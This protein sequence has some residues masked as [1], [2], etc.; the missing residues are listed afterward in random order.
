[1]TTTSQSLLFRY[2][3]LNERA[4]RDAAGRAVDED[5][6]R[7][8]QDLLGAWW[9][10]ASTLGA[11]HV[12]GLRDGRVETG[13]RYAVLLRQRQHP[14]TGARLLRVCVYTEGESQAFAPTDL[15]A[16]EGAVAYES[17]VD[18]AGR[19]LA[20]GIEFSALILGR[21]L[22]VQNR[23]GAGAAATMQRLIH[24]AGRCVEGSRFVRPTFVQVTPR[25]VAEQIAR[26]GGVAAVSFAPLEVQDDAGAR[27][28][29]QDIVAL[30]RR[31]G[32]SGR[33]KISAGGDDILDEEESLK[34]FDDPTGE[35][36]ENVR[37]HLKNNETISG[38]RM[39]MSHHVRIELRNGVPD[40]DRV[41]AALLDYLHALMAVDHAGHQAI[42]SEG[43]IGES[44]RVMELRT[45]RR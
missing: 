25:D 15:N 9:E 20:P 26:A 28:N 18:E 14:G 34:L 23:A 22:L 10:S 43:I 29:L 30:E 13:R 36:L 12:P 7:P 35:G 3:H 8:L 24:A 16:Q 2:L 45:H 1:M 39:A 40:C 6:F 38:E 31:L 4:P 11:R 33:V 19:I 27:A 5:R 42:S 37:L 21:V 41:D 17:V 32:G 44:L